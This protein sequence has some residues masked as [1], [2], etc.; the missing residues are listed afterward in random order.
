VL[1]FTGAGASTES[2]IPD[3]RTPG[4]VWSRYPNVKYSE[5]L[6]SIE[7][8]EAFWARGREL[9]PPL[10][11]AWPNA[12]HRLG[13]AL[14]AQWRLAGV[15]T[16]NVDGLHTAA[17]LAPERVVELHGNAHVV[18]CLG[19]GWECERVDVQR[20]LE[21]GE[22]APE[23]PRCGGIL[24]SKTVMFGQPVPPEALTRARAL[25]EE[26]DLC[27]VIGSA[28]QV[29]PAAYV[30]HWARR[31]GARLAILNAERTRLDNLCVVVVH[32]LAAETIS[33]LGLDLAHDE[34]AL[35]AGA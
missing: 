21:A 9:Y 5:L 32:G 24:K 27:L 11:G 29:Y 30:P 7:A 20:R 19:C 23:C 25:A 10:L 22:R 17:G 13:V 26:C 28:L 34:A 18:E 6:T 1:L 15:A 12:V 35:A 8:R 16:Q 14:E 31:A 4:G 3:Y 2:G 33:A